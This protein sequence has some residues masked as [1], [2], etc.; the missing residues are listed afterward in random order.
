MIFQNSESSPLGGFRGAEM[1][2]DGRP[3]R[4]TRPPPRIPDPIDAPNCYADPTLGSTPNAP[5]GTCPSF[6]TPPGPTTPRSPHYDPAVRP[7]K[8]AYSLRTKHLGSAQRGGSIR[9]KFKAAP[10][11]LTLQSRKIHGW[12][13]RFHVAVPWRNRRLWSFGQSIKEEC[14]PLCGK[15]IKTLP[16]FLTKH[17][18]EARCFSYMS[19]RIT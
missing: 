1:M 15:A 8:R 13:F 16:P 11:A 6:V 12:V 5:P 7:E 4:L 14:P 17:L 3:A 9:L 2:P 19:T 10:W 18:S